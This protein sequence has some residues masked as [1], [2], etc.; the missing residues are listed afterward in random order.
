MVLQGNFDTSD[1]DKI[2]R[3]ILDSLQIR[4]ED[5]VRTEISLEDLKAKYTSWSESTSTSPSGRHLGHFK[6]LLSRNPHPEALDGNPNPEH[7][8]FLAKRGHIWEVHHQMLNYVLLHGFSYTR[9]QT[10]VKC[11]IEKDLS[12]P[13]IHRLRVIQL[14]ENDYNLILAMKWRTLTFTNE[15]S[16]TLSSGQYGARP[17]LTAY[18]PVYIE[19]LQNEI[20]RVSRRPYVKFSND[21]TA[22][23]DRMIPNLANLASMAFGM[24]PRICKIQGE[25]LLKA[26]YKLKTAMRVSDTEYH[27]MDL[28][29]IYG[30]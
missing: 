28:F 17:G 24:D 14:Y 11:L 2:T 21:A 29:P 7:D 6:A 9:W 18:D 26:K 15:T 20:T 3:L 30:T 8:T 22:C 5:I 23:Y 10:V 25:T 27:H 12:Q 1:F 13:K 19:N 4:Q 16:K